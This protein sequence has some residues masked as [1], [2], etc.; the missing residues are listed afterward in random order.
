LRIDQYLPDFAPHDAIGNHVL[1]AQRVLRRA[2]IESDIWADVIHAPLA[3]TARPYTEAPP[4]GDAAALYHLSTHSDMAAW[5]H[6]R[7]GAGQRLLAYYHNIT[8]AEYFARWEPAAARSCVAARDEMRLLAGDTE[9]ALAA[10]GY[11]RGELEE[12]GY[13]KAVTSPLLLDLE[14]YHAP[15]AAAA[16]DRIRRKRDGGG[17]RWLFVGRLA[18]NKCQ[19]DVIAAFAAYR[20][21]FDPRATLVLPG[22]VTSPRYLNAMHAMIRDLDLGGSVELPGGLAF[23]DL[24]AEFA[25]ADVFVSC[26]E[27]EGFCVPVIEAMELGVPVVAYGAAAVPETVNGA[28]VVLDDKDPLVV[29]VAVASLLAD[30]GR[31]RSL[32]EAGRRRAADFSLARTS[33]QFL[34]HIASHLP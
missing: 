31:R 11:N 17:A 29:A 23:G 21:A 27:H 3:G 6:Q 8:P 4:A 2:G 33:K 30:D 15:P 18:P 12:A 10:S 24:L 13:P 16:V 9:L 1:Q 25:T 34:D 19:H 7:A 26:S 14:A 5:L 32:I 20:K 22:G 28:G